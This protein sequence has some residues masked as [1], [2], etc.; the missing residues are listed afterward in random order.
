MINPIIF[1]AEAVAFIVLTTPIAWERKN[2][3]GPKGDTNKKQDVFYRI[4]IAAASCLAN[5]IVKTIAYGWPGFNLVL[6][7][8]ILS[9]ALMCF[10]LFFFIF[11][12][13]VASHFVKGSWKWFSYLGER[14]WFDNFHLWVKIGPWGRFFIKFAVLIGALLIYF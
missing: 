1:I 7:H 13:W 8:W 5:V 14:G 4:L 12:Y 10:A 9:A 6:L 3:T 2:D 11:D